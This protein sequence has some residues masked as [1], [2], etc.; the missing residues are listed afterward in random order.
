MWELKRRATP[1]CLIQVA[2][3]LVLQLVLPLAW[4]QLMLRTFAPQVWRAL[5]AARQGQRVTAAGEVAEDDD[6]DGVEGLGVDSSVMVG[7]VLKGLGAWMLMYVG[8]VPWENFVAMMALDPTELALEALT[9]GGKGAEGENGVGE[10][11][12]EKVGVEVPPQ[13]PTTTG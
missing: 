4:D 9:S 11:D 10:V 7:N 5:S 8:A 13:A 1:L 3:N 6:E 12:S 2:L